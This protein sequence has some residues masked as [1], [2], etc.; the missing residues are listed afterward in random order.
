MIEAC[1]EAISKNLVVALQDMGAAGLTSSSF[2]MSVSGGLGL[3]LHLD[4]VP[5]RDTTLT[6]EEILLSESQERMLLISKPGDWPQV[7]NIFKKWGLEVCRIGRVQAE[8]YIELFWQE[9]PLLKI[10][11]ACIVKQAPVYKREYQ[12][13]VKHLVK[14]KAEVVPFQKKYFWRF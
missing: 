2:E 7:A 4:R 1:L 5:L 11:P 14:E 8:P 13:P 6:P 3:Q 12:K 10:D 9:K